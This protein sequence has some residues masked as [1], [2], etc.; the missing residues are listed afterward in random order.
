M[1]EY[2][3]LLTSLLGISSQMSIVSNSSNLSGNSSES[4]GLTPSHYYMNYMCSSQKSLSSR[5]AILLSPWSSRFPPT[6][7][8]CIVGIKNAKHWTYRFVITFKK[9]NLHGKTSG[10]CL[11]SRLDLYN[12]QSVSASDRLN[13]VNGLCGT[14]TNRDNYETTTS[15]LT[16]VYRTNQLP[17]AESQYFEAVITPFHRGTC[18]HDEFKCKNGNCIKDDML[19]DSYNNCGDDSDE[20]ACAKLAV[21][22]IVGIVVGCVVFLAI[23]IG[24]IV[25][26][27]CCGWCCATCTYE[28]L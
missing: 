17:L 21:A 2:L 19:C 12:G 3:L 25:C 14:R 20:E 4:L 27:C 16:L 10:T 11:K 8:T 22:L 5:D 23:V 24:I 7:K 18:K 6:T 13:D 15:F 1:T 28:S 9:M 26:C